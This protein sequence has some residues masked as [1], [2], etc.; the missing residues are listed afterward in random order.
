MRIALQCAKN[1]IKVLYDD[2]TSLLTY[3]EG[4]NGV[5]TVNKE[6]KNLQFT[7]YVFLE[8]QDQTWWA[9]SSARSKLASH[10]LVA[11]CSF[12]YGGVVVSMRTLSPKNV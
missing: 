12:D 10:L 8:T 5:S 9:R 4:H 2:E 1:I 11:Q 6:N 3:R 7:V